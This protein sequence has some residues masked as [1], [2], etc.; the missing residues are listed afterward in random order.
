MLLL[1]IL[2]SR[3]LNNQKVH[4]KHKSHPNLMCMFQ[5]IP[6]HFRIPLINKRASNSDTQSMNE[7]QSECTSYNDTLRSHV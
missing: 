3:L 6:A 1:Q 2:N 7:I 4:W 5:D